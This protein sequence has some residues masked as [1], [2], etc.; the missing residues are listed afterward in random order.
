MKK[1]VIFD[2]DG[3]LLNTIADLANSTNYALKVL[4]YPIH[5]PD[6]YN[7]MV[8]N[9][10][11]K[12]FERALPDGEK[13][14]ENV[15]RVRQEFVPYYDQHNADKSRPYPGVTELLETLQTAGMQLAVA[16]N[17]YQAATEKLIAHYF[18]NIKFTAVFGQ[19]EGIPVKPDPI[20]VKE[21]LQIA[22]VQ[23]EETLYAG[24][25][26]VDMQ[27]AINAGVTSCG[28]TWGFRPR[29]ELEEFNPDYIVTGA[30]EIIDII[31]K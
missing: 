2:L 16:S 18:P 27:T 26:G 8:G 28:V 21:I 11:N 7:F 22:K 29:T 30:K 23:E 20:I 14:E 25:S 31:K 3:T 17:K 10:I 4:G 19:R 5:E 24:D 12:L 9:G 15:L 13:T 1:L 6:K